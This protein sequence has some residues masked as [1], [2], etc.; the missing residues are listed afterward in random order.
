MIAA[1]KWEKG[2]I[3]LSLHF[4]RSFNIEPNTEK[5]NIRQWRKRRRKSLTPFLAAI[6]VVMVRQA[7]PNR[8]RRYQSGDWP[9]PVIRWKKWLIKRY[10]KVYSSIILSH[11]QIKTN[12]LQP[13]KRNR[14]KEPAKE[15][16]PKQSTTT[17]K[18]TT[19]TPE[20][21]KPKLLST[22]SPFA[23]A[24][25]AAAKDSDDSDDDDFNDVKKNS[26]QSWDEIMKEKPDQPLKLRNLTKAKTEPAKQVEKDEFDEFGICDDAVS[27]STPKTDRVKETVDEV[28]IEV[29]E[30]KAKGGGREKRFF[31]GKREEPKYVIPSFGEEQQQQ[32]SVFKMPTVPTMDDGTEPEVAIPEAT[33]LTDEA[34]K[35]KEFAD[36]LRY[37]LDGLNEG[38]TDINLRA[39]S[40]LGLAKKCQDEEF[41]AF[42]GAKKLGPK[43]K[44]HNIGKCTCL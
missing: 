23:L 12:L 6:A 3:K 22:R 14:R 30:K 39:L 18:T 27:L 15:P 43:N 20:S 13:M 37:Y 36:D 1:Y 19:L 2:K 33:R 16:S 28:P 40:A 26:E 17:T 38:A 5:Q 21:K 10:A 11:T 8:K 41:R 29:K 44:A 31:K 4:F 24:F 25:G 35:E 9:G 7:R 32:Q 42:L 34:A